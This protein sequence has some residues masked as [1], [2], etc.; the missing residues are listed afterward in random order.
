MNYDQ[1][2]SIAEQ[3]KDAHADL[4]VAISKGERVDVPINELKRL[5]DI[6][7]TTGME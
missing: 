1:D 2:K 3:I 5:L 6:A 7:Q 4:G